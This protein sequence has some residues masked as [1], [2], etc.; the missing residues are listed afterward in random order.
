MLIIYFYNVIIILETKH[1][2]HALKKPLSSNVTIT[3]HQTSEAHAVE[4]RWSSNI[5]IRLDQ[6]SSFDCVG[7]CHLFNNMHIVSL[8]NHYL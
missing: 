3:C 2:F 7:K 5:N 1:R 8:L 6:T 4:N